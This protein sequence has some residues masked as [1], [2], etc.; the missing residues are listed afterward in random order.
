MR[1]RSLMTNV[2]SLNISDPNQA[3]RFAYT[4]PSPGGSPDEQ[5]FL[6][7]RT[8]LTRLTVAA[9][10][11]GQILSITPPYP[12]ATYKID[13][14]GPMVKCKDAS[15]DIARQIQAAAERSK[16]NVNE[17]L[18]EIQN[19]YFAFVPDLSKAGLAANAGVAQ[20]TN[21]TNTNGAAHGSNE[22]W[23]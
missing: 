23:L 17:S 1:D 22:L 21:H 8:I 20:V 9:V 19:S 12:N 10:T 11:T 15:L 13:F 5:W 3:H 6:R 14:F 16:S 4:V 18:V 2:F 7:P